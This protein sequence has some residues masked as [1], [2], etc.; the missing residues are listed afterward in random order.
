MKT[1][2]I[3]YT[4]A[5]AFLLSLPWLFVAPGYLLFIGFVPLL[6]LENKLAKNATNNIRFE[7]SNYL[8]ITFS[9]W[10]LLSAWWLG[11]ATLTGFIIFLFLNTILM[12]GIWH[13]YHLMKS[14]TSENLALIFLVSLWL[15]FEFLHL[16]WDIQL[17]GM[18]LGGAFG[19]QTHIIQW[20]E[21]TGELGG[22]LWILLINILIYKLILKSKKWRV[23][24]Q[25]T[26][27]LA[28]FI[29]LPISLSL[30]LYHNYEEK[31]SKLN[32]RILQPNINPYTE[33]F[34]GLS[35]DEQLKI[36]SSLI[37]STNR[38]RLIIAPETALA[39]FWEDSIKT[40][41]ELVQLKQTLSICPNS[42]II[43][44]ANTKR[45][46]SE[47]DISSPTTRTLESTEKEYEEY[48]SAILFD[49]N[50]E[51]QIYH[52]NILVS[53]VEKVPFV[54]YFNPL[55]NFFFDLGGTAGGLKKGKPETFL[56]GDSLKF[57]SAICFESMFGEYMG[58]LT[59]KGGTFFVVITNDGW[60]KKSSGTALHFS[61]SRLRA[62]ETRRDIV[63]SANTGISGFIN[64]RGDIISKT[65]W[66]TKTAL[67]GTIKT[68][69]V[70]T[71][72]ARYGDYLGRIASFISVMLLL[73]LISIKLKT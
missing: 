36:I 53:G 22:S 20:Y 35:N 17:P 52:K 58:K 8:F 60:W 64:Q 1:K 62:I 44:G 59:Q 54:K 2:N 66:W 6:L 10:N 3:V 63:R 55:R 24:I 13:L 41:N 25:T 7:F 57:C 16:N 37:D 12:S 61:Y 43:V 11:Y 5:S 47:N 69:Q 31:G 9:L 51:M 34:N 30:Y 46:L 29:M 32:L 56:L 15:A 38:P 48:N 70:L 14:R 23:N 68:N 45:F 26:T 67:N 19:N 72:Y 42:S 27:I 21:Y 65:T 49:T 33:K 73:F 18:T 50:T 71:F 40:T 39:P 4:L 28:V